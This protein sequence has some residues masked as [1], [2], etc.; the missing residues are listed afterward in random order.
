MQHQ[1]YINLA[2]IRGGSGLSHYGHVEGIPLLT[3]PED[4]EF[5]SL[6]H[7]VYNLCKGADRVYMWMH[8]IGDHILMSLILTMLPRIQPSWDWL[9]LLL[10]LSLDPKPS[11]CYDCVFLVDCWLHV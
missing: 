6:L 10:T 11:S 3:V 4:A 2:L 9:C 8:P 7:L 5:S 1:G